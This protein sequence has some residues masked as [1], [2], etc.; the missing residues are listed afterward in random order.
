METQMKI[1]FLDVDGVLNNSKLLTPSFCTDESFLAILKRIVDETECRLVLTSTWRLFPSEKAIV[2]KH[3]SSVGLVLF[4]CTIDISHKARHQEIKEWLQGK[5]ITRFAIVDDEE[6]AGI[7]LEDNFFQT[8]EDVGL[9]EQI[10]DLI[11]SHLK[12]PS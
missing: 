10:A 3:L 9:T 11:I 4:D 8:D 2:E 12:T 6:F 5:S 1:L 7:G